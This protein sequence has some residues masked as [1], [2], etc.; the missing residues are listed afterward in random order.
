MLQPEYRDI[1]LENVKKHGPQDW[2]EVF[3]RVVGFIYK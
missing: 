1:F 2:E 3:N